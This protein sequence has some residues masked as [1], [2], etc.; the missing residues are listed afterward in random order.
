VPHFQ[1]RSP[2]YGKIGNFSDNTWQKIIN[3]TI[4]PP[5][6]DENEEKV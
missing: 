1:K 2:K 3:K 5:V 6:L 4:V